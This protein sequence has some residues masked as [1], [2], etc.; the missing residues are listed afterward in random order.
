[1]PSSRSLSAPG[2]E[3]TCVAV[4]ATR[5]RIHLDLPTAARQAACV[6][7]HAST[8]RRCIT[9]LLQ[10]GPKGQQQAALDAA[11]WS[12][13]PPT[14]GLGGPGSILGG[15]RSLEHAVQP[16]A[17]LRVGAAWVSLR[18]LGGGGA[19]GLAVPSI[20]SGRHPLRSPGKARRRQRRL[21][22]LGEVSIGCP[23]QRTLGGAERVHGL[24]HAPEAEA[25]PAHVGA[26]P[27]GCSTAGG[28][29]L[30]TSLRM[31]TDRRKGTPQ[32]L[33]PAARA[34]RCALVEHVH[35][36]AAVEDG[37]VSKGEDG[38]GFGHC[39]RLGSGP[40]DYK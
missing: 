40:L 20:S 10:A 16:L 32:L 2:N 38:A 25:V 21:A 36:Y 22:C 34:S 37:R 17:D 1:M 24:M 39:G 27:A 15:E 7:A 30:G 26:R 12:R 4:H 13:L 29:E 8:S 3:D 23:A 18:Q 35:A 14:F 19:P 31:H 33:R 9:Q 28:S 5:P 11:C 6:G